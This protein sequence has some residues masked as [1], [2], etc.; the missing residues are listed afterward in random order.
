MVEQVSNNRRIA[1]NTVLL[2]I[3]TFFVML[4]SLYTS[5]V[6]LQVLGVEDYG[7]YQVVGGMV[8]MFAVIS[9]A[10][11]TAISRFITYEIGSGNHS[12][13]LE[14]FSTSRVVQLTI[15]GIVL[16]LGEI[17][18]LWFLHTYMQIPEGRMVAANWVLQFS[19]VAFCTNLLNIPY[20]ACIIAHEHMKAFAYITIFEAV[21]KL[22]ICFLILT[23]P[24]DSLIYYALLLMLLAFVLF[25]LY[26]FYC[27][28]MFEECHSEI[29]FHKPIFK[30]MFGFAGWSF[31]SNTM[32][33]FN[34]QGVN[35]LINV[36]FGVSVNA[37]RGISNQVES[38]VMQFVN[39]FTIAIN[40]Q[41]T[42]SYAAGEY[43]SMY[44]L[45]CRGA[46][47][48][49]FLMLMMALPLMCEADI[50]L[51]LWLVEVP[52]Q[53]VILVQLSL[54]LGLLDA[55]G[56]SGYT[57]CLATGRLKKYALIITS[58][59]IMEFPLSWVAFAIGGVVEISY[60]I[61]IIVKFAVLIA[62]MILLRDMVGLPVRKYVNEVFCPILLTT[63]FSII[64]SIILVHLMPQSF[65]RLLLSLVIGV[66]I[67]GVMTLFI[68]MSKGERE[69]VIY[70]VHSYIES[71]HKR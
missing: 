20:N 7:V 27:R 65:L 44:V 33:I 1:K 41:I 10:L 61:Y 69:M 17:I 38:A 15:S 25:F 60:Y 29:Y 52:P 66:G 23:S 2:Y 58:I 30:E 26:K 53:A 47:F 46:K 5:R 45:V 21:C 48:S 68:G 71:L 14:V 22:G 16:I 9:N 59:G 35:M 64:P 11:A 12:R 49:Y 55:I 54:V 32:H 18:G 70:K 40:P 51:R 19:L 13:L 8:A 34:S 50:I 24:I 36:F 67:T 56:L 4:I 62:R 31:F 6:L 63:F 39:S 3:R 42:K 28:K 37:A 57:A 43:E